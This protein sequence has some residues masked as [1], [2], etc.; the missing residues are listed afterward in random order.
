MAEDTA[1]NVQADVWAEEHASGFVHINLRTTN[2]GEHAHH[3]QKPLPKNETHT[4]PSSLPDFSNLAVI[5]RNT[6]P[7]RAAFFVYDNA[8]DAC[9]RDVEKSKTFCLSGEWKFHLAKCPFDAPQDFFHPKFDP[10]SWG[11]IKV[12]GMWQLQGYGKGPQ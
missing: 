2:E 1:E 3:E 9:S 8:S 4:F 7:A 6:L 10:T 12:P 5:H 11:S